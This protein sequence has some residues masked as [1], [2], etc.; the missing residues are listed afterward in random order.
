MDK[1]S[2]NTMMGMLQDSTDTMKVIA[3]FLME[4]KLDN[5]EAV[6]S[7]LYLAFSEAL[8]TLPKSAVLHMAVS[9][10]EVADQHKDAVSE[11][12]ENEEASTSESTN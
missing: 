10:C 12:Y 2:Y 6:V 9:L 1:R 8:Q 5:R 11:E 3:E 4:A 7:M